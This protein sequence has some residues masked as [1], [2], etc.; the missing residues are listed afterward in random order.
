MRPDTA[1]SM[2]EQ[3]EAKANHT[4]CCFNMLEVVKGAKRSEAM[5]LRVTLILIHK[6]LTFV[7]CYILLISTIFFVSLLLDVSLPIDMNVCCRFCAV[8]DRGRARG[9]ML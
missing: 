9:S 3:R 2:M 4:S 1:A 8:F 5:T 7:I 6:T